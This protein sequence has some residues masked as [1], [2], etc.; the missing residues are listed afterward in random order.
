[1]SKSRRSPCPD[2]P[3]TYRRQKTFALGACNISTTRR[4]PRLLRRF[5]YPEIRRI[6]LVN[7]PRIAQVMK[8]LHPSSVVSPTPYTLSV[9][10]PTEEPAL[11]TVANCIRVLFMPLR[12]RCPHCQARAALVRIKPIFGEKVE[13][14]YSC[15]KCSHTWVV[16]AL[17]PI[18]DA[19]GWLQ[20]LR[21]PK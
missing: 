7:R 5:R 15:P 19:S 1:M 14:T 9:T 16:T 21:A 18:H 8:R 11:C 12:S 6:G 10:V 13:E 20:S 3:K 17:D 2:C 4:R